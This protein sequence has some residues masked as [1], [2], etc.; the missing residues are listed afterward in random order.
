MTKVLSATMIVAAHT[1]GFCPERDMSFADSCTHIPV[2]E[3]NVSQ[4]KISE[5]FLEDIDDSDDDST[6]CPSECSNDNTVSEANASQDDITENFR[7]E[8]D[9][10]DDFDGVTYA[11]FPA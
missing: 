5:M 1:L 2:S 9:D 8:I 4:C 7:D 3:A 6:V 11:A 10:F